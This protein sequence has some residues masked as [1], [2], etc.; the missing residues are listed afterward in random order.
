MLSSRKMKTFGI[1][2]GIII[3]VIL[4]VLAFSLMGYDA[5]FEHGIDY[6]QNRDSEIREQAIEWLIEAR[7]TH[8]KVVDHPEWYYLDI[9]GGV[10]FHQMWVDRYTPI[11]TYLEGIDEE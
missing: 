2:I 6:M 8:Q 9:I 1:A 7:K 5:G 3:G 11:I 4:V 10:E